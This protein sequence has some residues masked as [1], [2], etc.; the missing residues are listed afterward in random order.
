MTNLAACL[1]IPLLSMFTLVTLLVPSQ[2]TAAKPGEDLA[3]VAFINDP[4]V[5]I[6]A[7]HFSM[8]ILVVNRGGET[9]EVEGSSLSTTAG[10][11]ALIDTTEMKFRNQMLSTNGDPVGRAS[12]SSVAVLPPKGFWE[13]EI[14][15][16]IH[17]TF[18]AQAGFYRLN[19]SASVRAGPPS[20]PRDVFSSSS[21]ILELRNCES[22]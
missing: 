7:P 19:L 15:I 17:G 22:K 9:V 14:E 16:P 11:V 4:S 2:P 5:C 21:A 10:F 6:G 3:I 1:R 12:P 18:F 13:K 8:R 20:H